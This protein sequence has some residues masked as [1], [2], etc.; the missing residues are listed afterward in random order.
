MFFSI[1]LTNELC[2]SKDVIKPEHNHPDNDNPTE[3]TI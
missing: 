1:E 2:A 3:R